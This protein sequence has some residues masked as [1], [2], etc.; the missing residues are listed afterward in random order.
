MIRKLLLAAALAYP[1]LAAAQ[2]GATIRQSGSVTPGHAVEWTTNGVVQDAGTAASGSLTSLGVTASGPGIC[3]NS[4]A[5]SSAAWQALCLGVTTAGGGTVN[6]TPFGTATTQNITSNATWQMP[7]LILPQ[8]SQPVAP[9]NGQIWTTSSGV[10][11]YIAGGVV[12]PFG[13]GGGGGGSPGGINGQVQYNNSGSFGGLTN[14]QLTADINVA[15]ASLSGAVPAWPNNTSTFFR[16]DGTYAALVCANLPALTGD[17]TSSGCATT[18]AT[19]NS[20]VGT[21]GSVTQIPVLTVNAKGLVTAASQ[22]GLTYAANNLTGTTLNS[23]VVSSGLTSVGTLTGGAAAAGFTV[24]ASNVTWTGTVPAVNLPQA[25]SSTFGVV[26]PDNSTITIS[27]GILSAPGSGGGTVSNCP[28]N[29]IGYFAAMGTTLGCL[30]TANSAILATSAGGVP[31]LATALP[32]SFG[33]NA[34]NITWSGTIS[35]SV[36]PNANLAAS[37]NGGVTGNLPVANLNSGTN[38]GATTFWR[39]DGTWAI[40][41]SMPQGRLTL[42][43]ATPVMASNQTAKGTLYYDCYV[44][45]QVPYYNGTSDLVDTVSACEV[46]DAM[47][48]AASA[49]QVVSGQVYDVWWVHGGA[50]RICLAM[51]S[52]SG[53][54]GGWASDTGGSNTARGTGYSQLDFTTRPYITNKNSISNCFNGAT[55]YGSVSANQATYLGTIYATANGQTGMA[56]SVTASGGGANILGVFNAYNQVPFTAVSRDS[57]NSWASP[58]STTWRKADNNANNAISY[59]DGLGRL[60]V[61]ISYTVFAALATGG[62]GLFIGTQCDWTSGTPTFSA[63]NFAGGGGGT[64]NENQLSVNGLCLPAIGLHVVNALE[65]SQS[66]TPNNFQG[67]VSSIQVQ[68]LFATLQM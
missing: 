60:N 55:N 50:N 64:Y 59:V 40:P 16:G 21:W 53:G 47:V 44:G 17:I 11:A 39:G 4:A 51:S 23:G 43:T 49:G 22:V 46:S 52:S 27:G 37:G 6:L 26:E 8:G 20:N 25:T 42:V 18:L 66:S 19:V 3:Q 35:S 14:A 30:A 68:G 29:N 63:I 5:T 32:T 13:A 24:Q 54:G 33:I 12:G 56:Y 48:S 34:S 65:T 67:T 1:T 45:N 38:A 9:V 31:S 28:I 58:S 7:S 10:F 2:N 61:N 62:T 57:T 41:I 15:T 36:V